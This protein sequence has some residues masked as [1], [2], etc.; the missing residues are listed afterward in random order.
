MAGTFVWSEIL[1]IPT[2]VRI[3]SMVPGPY[4]SDSTN[5]LFLLAA[6][7]PLVLVFIW[8]GSV[9]SQKWRHLLFH[10]TVY[11]WTAGP[12]LLAFYP[13]LTYPTYE[14][15]GFLPMMLELLIV[16]GVS[17]FA[18]ELLS[19]RTNLLLKGVRAR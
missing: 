2:Q 3:R 13:L 1:S 15:G 6:L 12:L 9:F 8:P 19:R 10:P 5:F 18:I 7:A 16:Y 14:T 11:S 17:A 4:Q